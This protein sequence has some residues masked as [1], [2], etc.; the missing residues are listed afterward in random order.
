MTTAVP[1]AHLAICQGDQLY[2]YRWRAAQI[3]SL[4]CRIDL[5]IRCSYTGHKL[6]EMTPKPVTCEDVYEGVCSAVKDDQYGRQYMQCIA[7]P[8]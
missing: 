6:H 7:M 2:L 4:R 1:K 3:F 5:G 8:H